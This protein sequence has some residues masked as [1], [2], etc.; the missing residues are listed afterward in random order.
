MRGGP[1]YVLFQ[2]GT[3]QDFDQPLD[4]LD[5]R[6]PLCTEHRTGC[7]CREAEWSEEIREYRIEYEGFRKALADVLAGH[8]TECCQCT[9]CAILRRTHFTFL[10]GVVGGHRHDC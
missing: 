9:G 1:G 3:R 10:T 8:P 4:T 2:D 5:P 6:Y 7:I